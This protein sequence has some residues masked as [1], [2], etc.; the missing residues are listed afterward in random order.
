MDTAQQILVIFLSTALAIFLVLAITIAI[1]VLR[2]VKSAQEIAQKAGR[3]VNSAES[4][5]ETLRNSAGSFAA[6]KFAR[7]IANAFMERHSQKKK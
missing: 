1:M 2:L 3:V 7:V 4:L 5:T 6:L